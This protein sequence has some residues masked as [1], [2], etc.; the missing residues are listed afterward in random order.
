LFSNLVYGLNSYRPEYLVPGQHG[1]D[2]ILPE[3]CSRT[4]GSMANAAVREVRKVY[5]SV[6]LRAGNARFN[7][8]L[9]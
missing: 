7:D 4:A 1:K 8:Q 9:F 5:W 2:K 6:S 3:F